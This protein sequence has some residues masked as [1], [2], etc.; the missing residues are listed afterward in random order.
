M[1]LYYYK[2]P[3]G[4]F[5]DDLN[6]WLWPQL[7]PKPIEECFEDEILFVGI[8]SILNHKIPEYPVKK[9]VFG[10]GFGYGSPPSFTGHWR[11]HCV[12]GPLTARALKLPDYIAICDSAL[13]VRELIQ[14]AQRAEYSAAFM[15]HHTVA[16]YD[17]W[18][19]ICESLGIYYIDPTAPVANSVDAIRKSALV[20]SESLHG[21]IIA[22]A[23]RVPWIPVRTRPRIAE[24][25]WH[26]W[27]ASLQLEHRFE[28]L[29]PAWNKNIDSSLK[30]LLRPCSSSVAR[31]RL[32]WLMH[33]GKR[34]LSKEAVFKQVYARLLTAYG[35]LVKEAVDLKGIG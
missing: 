9:V 10:S 23:F 4:N 13:L 22:D 28:W 21:A 12:R 25:K 15:P 17:N 16:K 7:F 5:G 6:P 26:D 14:P 18:P 33:F 29:P 31:R 1:K 8:G 19:R 30:R 20:I 32:Q 11:F 24:F 2:D 27:C 34:R 3:A 35:E